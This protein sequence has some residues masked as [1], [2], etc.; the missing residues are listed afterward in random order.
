VAIRRSRTVKGDVPGGVFV[1]KEKKE[2]EGEKKM[3]KKE[4]RTGAV[5]RV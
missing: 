4:E 2:P 5:G 3:G 1:K